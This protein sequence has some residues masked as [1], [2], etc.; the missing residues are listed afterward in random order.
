MYVDIPYVLD[1]VLGSEARVRV[2]RFLSTETERASS[3]SEIA[4]GTGLTKQGVLKALQHLVAEGVVVRSGSGRSNVYAF[5]ADSPLLAPIRALFEAE[6]LM[7]ASLVSE[8]KHALAEV[9]SIDAAWVTGWPGTSSEP[10]EVH[11]LSDASALA[12]A[13]SD[14]REALL[15]IEASHDKVIEVIVHT[16]SDLETGDP[17]AVTMLAGIPVG[18]AARSRGVV[19]K[20]ETRARLMMQAVARIMAEEPSLRGRAIRHVDMLLREDRGMAANDLKEWAQ[21]LE[22]YSDQR[23]NDFLNSGSDRAM[24]LYQSMPFLAV[25]TPRERSRL[26]DMM[27]DER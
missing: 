6:V 7:T 19:R 14:T 9:H 23:L 12:Q 4:R 22:T 11:V 24:R 26:Q 15:S 8:L 21:I 13:R 25:L 17:G 2:V 20:G 18:S 5:R 10:L 3:V 27:D 16:P 1:S